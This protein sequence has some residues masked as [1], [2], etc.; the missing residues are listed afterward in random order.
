MSLTKKFVL[1]FLLVTLLPLGLVTW[2]SYQTLVE[3]AQQQIGA[4]LEDS[5]AQVG[6][7][8]DAFMLNCVSNIST[9][10]GNHDLGLGDHKLI[11]EDLSRFAFSVPYFNQ[12]MFVDTQGEIVASSHTLSPDIG[13]SLFTQYDST[14]DEFEL[15]LNGS[16][17][18]VYVS[19]LSD[20]SASLARAAAE[21]RLSNR[22]LN[23]RILVS[24]Q[25]GKGRCAGVLVG[26]IVTT[27]LLDLL[28]D[29]SRQAPG[30]E[31]PCLLDKAG[32]VL[33]STDPQAHLLS[34]HADVRSGA[35]RAALDSSKDGYL[36]YE[37]SHGRKLMAGYTALPTY[38]DNKVGMHLSNPTT[39]PEDPHDLQLSWKALG[40]GHIA[41]SKYGYYLTYQNIDLQS[42]AVR[43]LRS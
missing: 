9:L 26:D 2:V 12:L 14:R 23:I 28:Q 24:V 22:P 7:S 5:V 39:G 11:G 8:I 25:D 40:S 29:L 1:T 19:D 32:H 42:R 10:A 41:K 35:L 3:Q 30:D 16:Y 37:G 36:I 15:A 21:D 34:T 6:K 4:R 27:Q 13:T 18:S 43:C 33:M 38:G 17:G 20:V 31:F